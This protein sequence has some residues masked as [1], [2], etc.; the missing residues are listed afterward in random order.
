MSFTPIE[1]F[2]LD[3]PVNFDDFPDNSFTLNDRGMVFKLTIPDLGEASNIPLLKGVEFK[4]LSFSPLDSDGELTKEKLLFAR[5][6]YK[7]GLPL[8]FN[9]GTHGLGQISLDVRDFVIFIESNHSTYQSLLKDSKI[10]QMRFNFLGIHEKDHSIV[11]ACHADI[12]IDTITKDLPMEELQN[13]RFF[14]VENKAAIVVFT[15]FK[16]KSVKDDDVHHSIDSK[17]FLEDLAKAPRIKPGSYSFVA[18]QNWDDPQF[19]NRTDFLDLDWNYNIGGKFH[20][21]VG[22]EDEILDYYLS[23]HSLDDLPEQVERVFPPCLL[24]P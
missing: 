9:T 22:S 19:D 1:I 15:S 14:V 8:L 24:R 20:I 3:C 21:P 18:A 6:H 23:V 7:N 16:L 17:E 4:Y 2:P 5:V 12:F 11:K 13:E 10:L